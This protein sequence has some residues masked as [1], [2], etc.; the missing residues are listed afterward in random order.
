MNSPQDPEETWRSAWTEALDDLEL[1]VTAVETML[2]DTHRVDD[3]PV[4][5][6]WSPPEGLGPLPLDLRPRADG[7]LARQIAA[8]HELAQR[9][10]GTRRQVAAVAKVET[11]DSVPSR[12]AYL[13]CAM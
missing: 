13:D 11:R 8:T 5:D 1:D 10:V 3:T 4:A 7:I 6:P 2:A 9:M 12:P